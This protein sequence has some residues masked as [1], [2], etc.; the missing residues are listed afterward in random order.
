[1]GESFWDIGPPDL[2]IYSTLNFMFYMID[3]IIILYYGSESN[4][5]D[6]KIQEFLM[7]ISKDCSK[8]K[9]MA[10]D[11]MIYQKNDQFFIMK[12]QKDK[13]FYCFNDKKTYQSL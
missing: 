6:H 1:M 5:L 9:M 3:F 11:D 13:S 4:I 8:V 12:L 7:T 2:L 10:E